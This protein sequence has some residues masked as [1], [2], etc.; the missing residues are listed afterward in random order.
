VGALDL[1]FC[2]SQGFAC[3]ITLAGQRTGAQAQFPVVAACIDDSSRSS[4]LDRGVANFF[5][6]LT[7]F[8]QCCFPIRTCLPPDPV[9]VA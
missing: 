4:S 5:I 2:L 7:T 8:C 1:L 9:V 3:C 6:R